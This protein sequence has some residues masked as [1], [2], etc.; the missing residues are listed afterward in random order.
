MALGMPAGGGEGQRGTR[1]WFALFMM[2]D[3]VA[4]SF[5][6]KRPKRAAAPP[7]T[8]QSAPFEEGKTVFKAIDPG[9]RDLVTGITSNVIWKSVD[10]DEMEVD[11]QEKGR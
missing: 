2:T 11:G 10:E 1:R 7:L 5:L 3:G 4:C 6:C 9:L 8:P